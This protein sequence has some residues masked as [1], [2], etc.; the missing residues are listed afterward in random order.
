VLEGVEGRLE[1]S[2]RLFVPALRE[3]ELGEVALADRR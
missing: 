3:P 2:M 1:E